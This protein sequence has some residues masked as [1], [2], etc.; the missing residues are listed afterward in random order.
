MNVPGACQVLQGMQL[1]S[2]NGIVIE[3]EMLPRDIRH[4]N[5]KWGP[6]V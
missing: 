2:E 1:A 5:I 3:M 6:L 4:C